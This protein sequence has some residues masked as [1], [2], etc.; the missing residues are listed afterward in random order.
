MY[1]IIGVPCSGKTTLAEEVCKKANIE[2]VNFADIMHKT[3]VENGFQ[4][5]RDDMRKILST[6]ELKEYQIK[7]F[8]KI[9]DTEKQ[10]K[11]IMVDT[12]AFIPLGN[13]EYQNGFPFEV[14][15]TL[16]GNVDWWIFVYVSPEE[17]LQRIKED[18]SR[19]RKEL[20]NI[21]TI[22]K[23]I[24][25]EKSA[26]LNYAIIMGGYYMDLN[27]DGPPGSMVLPVLKALKR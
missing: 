27:N 7:T 1:M 23:L 6:D 2:L 16:K 20:E 8:K 24:N 12:H 21:N 5:T 14:H 25:M 19:S 10:G 15:E 17:L 4:G 22:K 13:E 18:K 3:A 11:K 26:V 9:I